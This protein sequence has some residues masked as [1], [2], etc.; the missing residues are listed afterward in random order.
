MGVFISIISKN[1]SIEAMINEIL[2][3]EVL[4]QSL[5]FEH[6]RR[7]IYFTDNKEG[8]LINYSSPTPFFVKENMQF[9]SGTEGACAL[10]GTV[11]EQ[12]K[13]V[14]D[15]PLLGAKDIINILPKETEVSFK[16]HYTGDFSF[17]FMS[18][19][20][21]IIAS[22]D[23]SSFQHIYYSETKDYIFISNR[24]RCI[25][26]IMKNSQIDL[27][28]IACLCTFET[29]LGTE[30][31]LKNVKRLEIN[32]RLVYDRRKGLYIEGDPFY[33]I[34]EI[35]DLNYSEYVKENAAVCVNRLKAVLNDVEDIEFPIT[36]GRDSRVNLAL[37]IQ[38]GQ[39]EKIHTYTTGYEDH[40]DVIVGKNI[41]HHYNIS[42]E[43]RER[44]PPQDFTDEEILEKVM[45]AVFQSDGSLGVWDANMYL[46]QNN[47]VYFPGHASEAFKPYANSAILNYEDAVDIKRFSVSKADFIKPQA[48]KQVYSKMEARV[49]RCKQ[50]G[51]TPKDTADSYKITD[52]L[53]NW[54]GYM[55][56][57]N[58]YFHNQI[59][60][61]NNQNLFQLSYSAEPAYRETLRIHYEILKEV[62]P[63]LVETPFAIHGWNKELD[64]YVNDGLN[65]SNAA[66]PLPRNMPFYGSWQ[67]KLNTS[68][69]LRM[70][71]WDILSS[72]DN[73]EFWDWFDRKR[74][75]TRI[76]RETHESKD[77]MILWNFI[78]SFC[79]YHGLEVPI[80]ISKINNPQKYI[81]RFE[82]Q[83]GIRGCVL[84]HKIQLFNCDKIQYKNTPQLHTEMACMSRDMLGDNEKYHLPVNNKMLDVLNVNYKDYLT[85]EVDT[86]NYLRKLKNKNYIVF[87]GARDNVPAINNNKITEEL[88][89]LGLKYEFSEKEISSYLAILNDEKVEKEEYSSESSLRLKGV[90]NGVSY[91][92]Y[93]ANFLTGNDC[94]LIINDCYYRTIYK[95]YFIVVFD[96]VLNK[97]VDCV[98]ISANRSWK[99]QRVDK[100]KKYDE[101]KNE[102]KPVQENNDKIK[103]QDLYNEKLCAIIKVKTKRKLLDIERENS[104]KVGKGFV[105]ILR[106][107]KSILKL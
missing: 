3:K 5:H 22:N 97:I 4:E 46:F 29:V 8:C 14:T 12:K 80:K 90:L 58:D 55:I 35:P 79:F 85:S 28:N 54:Q 40:P 53:P 60:V 73:S 51:L 13:E 89:N 37:L 7:D 75:E 18:P 66:I 15:V 64:K 21:E 78:G 20:G 32:S 16:E 94:C 76:L 43:F 1:N 38:A 91:D 71:V 49:E 45:G 6:S 77:L 93:S 99:L 26:N 39:R 81:P 59:Q 61:L 41:S 30:T 36:G 96:K 84:N 74:V 50:M 63:W 105:K 27:E 9:Y 23:S 42:H 57:Q 10:H 48:F 88:H 47:K 67:L 98:S 92:L 11:V 95:G 34:K 24:Q 70:K 104:L 17:V 31:V 44:K 107:T 87:I 19:K 62:D 33:F 65:I 82:T 103:S 102:S 2:S 83:S 56:R 101:V 52:R 100:F 25:R 106:K 86:V 72:F 68:D 69:A